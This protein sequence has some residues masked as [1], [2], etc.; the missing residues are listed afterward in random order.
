[1]KEKIKFAV[2]G[3]G[4]I[5]KRHAEMISRNNDASL[6]ALID[7]KARES[8][9]LDQY[10]VP[11]F[12]SLESF[13]ESDI[14]TDVITISTPNGFHAPQ[15][16]KALK[17]KNHVV[18]E[19]PLALS[20]KDAEDIIFNEVSRARALSYWDDVLKYMRGEMKINDLPKTLRPSTQIIRSLIDKQTELLQ[21]ILKNLNV[22]DEFFLKSHKV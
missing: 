14:D 13:L 8:L 16:I 5:G 12:N 18:V 2:V 4:H 15:A 22:K 17:A 21:P 1:L 19:K 6:V 7:V 9:N 11:F 20:K 3:C 10:T